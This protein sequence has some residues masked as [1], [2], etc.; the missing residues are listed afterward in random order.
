MNED[1]Y[2]QLHNDYMQIAIEQALIAESINE[3]PVGAVIVDNSGQVIAKGH[4]EVYSQQDPCAHAEINVIRHV[5]K[6]L[7]LASLLD[8]DLYV[9]LEPCTM[10]A[11]AIS[12]ARIKRLFFGAYDPKGGGVEHGVCFFSSKTCFHKPEIYGG[13]KE[14]ACK[15]I[16]LSFFNKLRR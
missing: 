9:T 7:G 5:T 10:C 16:L 2:S 3:V 8:C 11:G 13:I 1:Q 6:Q 4:N 15:E 12:L 14:L